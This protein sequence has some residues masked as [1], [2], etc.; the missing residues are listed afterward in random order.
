MSVFS[1][2]C[3]LQ[4]KLFWR[5]PAYCDLGCVIFG[6]CTGYFGMTYHVIFQSDIILLFQ[7]IEDDHSKH[8]RLKSDKD[9]VVKSDNINSLCLQ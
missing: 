4:G 8:G 9:L 2:Q 1:V 5:G 7:D 3:A 6:T